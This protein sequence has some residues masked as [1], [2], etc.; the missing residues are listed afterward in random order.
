MSI[1]RSTGAGAGVAGPTLVPL[2]P[3]GDLST[4]TGGTHRGARWG[5]EAVVHV[6][7]RALDR[8]DGMNEPTTEEDQGYR[9][10]RVLSYLPLP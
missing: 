9:L 3:L 2:V 7:K 1:G 6:T 10:P 8:S 5:A 4:S